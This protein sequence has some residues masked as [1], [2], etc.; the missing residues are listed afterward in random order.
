M[1][2]CVCVSACLHHALMPSRVCILKN[3]TRSLTLVSMLGI[4]GFSESVCVCVC[5]CVCACVCP[6]LLPS[7]GF[8]PYVRALKQREGR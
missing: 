4:K 8:E 7:D 5:V 1:C 6:C 2:V 3:L